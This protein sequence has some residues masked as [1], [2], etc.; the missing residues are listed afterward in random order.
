MVHVEKEGVGAKAERTAACI[1][2]AGS[3]GGG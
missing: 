3:G 1:V 2:K